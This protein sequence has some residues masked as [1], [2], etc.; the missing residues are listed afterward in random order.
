MSGTSNGGIPY[1][2]QMKPILRKYDKLV[3][4]NARMRAILGQV[5]E[6]CDPCRVVETFHAMKKEIRRRENENAELRKVADSR[7]KK[8]EEIES[9]VEEGL[10][11]IG[12][13]VPDYFP[14]EPTIESLFQMFDYL[15][16]KVSQP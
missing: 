7:K 14:L 11:S 8:L 12:M 6:I 2:R 5:N 13:D 16:T 1:E 9:I 3:E 4:E 10:K 15:K